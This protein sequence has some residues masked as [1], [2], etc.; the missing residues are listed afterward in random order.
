M[1]VST[2]K[3]TH[4]LHELKKRSITMVCLLL[5]VSL[6][7]ACA[8]KEPEK[9]IVRTVKTL[10]ITQNASAAMDEF[11]GEIRARVESK[12]G[13]RVSGKIMERRVDVGDMVSP[14]QVL[15]QLDAQD[16]K[17]M[18]QQSDAALKA[19]LSNRDLAKADLGRYQ[20]LHDK[21]FVSEATLDAK[22]TAYASAQSSYEQALAASRNQSNQTTYSSLI[23]DIRGVVTAVNAEVGQV[24][25]AGTPVISVAQMEDKDVVIS[26]PEN[27]VDALQQMQ[28]VSIRLW[29]QPNATLIGK[30]REISPIADPVTRT[31]LVKVALPKTSDEVKLG[32]TAYAALSNAVSGHDVVLPLSA[33]YK[34]GDQTAVWIVKNNQVHL[35]PVIISGTKNNDVLIASGVQQGDQVVTAGVNVLKEGQT[36]KLLDDAVSS[37]S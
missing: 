32:M 7:S 14:H 27:K 3:Y 20:E 19:A 13:F 36:V 1:I 33:L 21:N 22:K 9:E 4:A 8:K 2:I 5:C 29:A 26:V 28:E 25:A 24:V 23:S 34:K 6:L 10:T 15:M 35:T 12:L 31:Y 11:S 30:I 16:L 18:Q 37:A 17:L